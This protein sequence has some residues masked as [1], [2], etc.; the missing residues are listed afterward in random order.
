MAQM[1]F[2]LPELDRKKTQAAVEAAFKKYRIYKTTT[3]EDREAS[4]TASWSDSPGGFTG[5][6]S[7]QTGD[8]AAYNIDKKRERQ[9]YCERIERVVKRLHPSERL[10]IDERYMKEDYVFDYV[11]YN[12]KF[13]PPI[14]QKKYEKF[15][16][17]AFYQIALALDIAVE[18]ERNKL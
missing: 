2:E 14:S 8:I 16:R 1:S 5:T 10:L 6:T 4:T 13:N 11:V 17:N 3:F 7:D 18:K 15:R 9:L 12:H